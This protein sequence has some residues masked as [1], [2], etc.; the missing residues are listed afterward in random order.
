MINA[1][2]S[3]DEMLGAVIGITRSQGTPTAQQEEFISR[4][5]KLAGLNEKAKKQ[6]GSIAEKVSFRLLVGSKQ[7]LSEIEN[8]K[9]MTSI[10]AFCDDH[11]RTP[12]NSDEPIYQYYLQFIHPHRPLDKYKKKTLELKKKYATRRSVATSDS[13]KMRGG[14]GNEKVVER[15]EE[16]LAFCKQNGYRPPVNTPIGRF[17]DKRHSRRADPKLVEKLE[18][19]CETY[20]TKNEKVFEELHTNFFLFVKKHKRLP[21]V[22]IPNEKQLAN[23]A[24]RVRGKP[25]L[26]GERF[27][28]FS[29]AYEDVVTKTGKR[30]KLAS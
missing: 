21:R 17:L 12:G 3:A 18:E 6:I 11:H 1:I 19:V 8:K 27:D 5:I 2:A 30:H 4:H 10:I 15:L 9:R 14:L 16:V 24:I 13:H 23:W 22:S 20:P 26:L 7:R 29:Q 25:Y 28:I